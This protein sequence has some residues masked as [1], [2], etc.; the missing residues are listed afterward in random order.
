M[1][2]RIRFSVLPKR[3][4]VVDRIMVD[5]GEFV[6]AD[7]DAFVDYS[8]WCDHGMPLDQYNKYV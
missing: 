5:H 8:P 4:S 2:M 3:V 7:Y 1:R 6:M